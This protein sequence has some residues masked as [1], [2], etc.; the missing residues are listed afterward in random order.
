MKEGC[1]Q[2]DKYYRTRILDIDDDEELKK[3]SKIF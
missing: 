1:N 3:N 2:S